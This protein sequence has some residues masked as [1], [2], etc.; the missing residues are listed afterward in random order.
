MPCRRPADAKASSGRRVKAPASKTEK[1]KKKKRKNSIEILTL[2]FCK[3]ILQKYVKSCACS[4][5]DR[6]PGYE[7][8]G[9]RFESFQARQKNASP[10]GLAFFNE[11]HA[12]R[13]RNQLRL[14]KPC[15]MKSLPRRV[16]FIASC[17][18]AHD[19]TTSKALILVF[20]CNGITR[21][22]HIVPSLAWY[23][24]HSETG[25]C[26]GAYTMKIIGISGSARKDGNTA[27]LINMMFE[28]FI[29]QGI[30]TELIQFAGQVIE[31]CKACWACGGK[32]NC[33]HKNDNFQEVFEK[34]T[35]ADGVILGSPVYSANISS[36][37][38]AFLERS[39][40]VCDMNAGLMKHKVGA[41]VAAVRRAGALQAIDT[42]NHFFL[43]HEMFVAGSTYWNMVYGQMPGDVANDEEGIQNIRNL[44]ENMAY[45]LKK[46]N[47]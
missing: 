21:S 19:F 12:S 42:I 31:P 26:K 20:M 28:E 30:E 18:R 47:Q 40:V 13:G 39:A 35:Q 5:V 6:V 2:G 25:I 38:Q 16:D 4:S 1:N 7:P 44:A 15:R 14:M 9:R 23:N 45:L 37:M 8:V 3:A 11:I 27:Q 29:A 33:I 43:N 46:V 22:V 41:A 10:I 32:N 17:G 34:M 24:V 36:S